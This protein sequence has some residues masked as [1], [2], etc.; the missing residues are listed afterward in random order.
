MVTRLFTVPMVDEFMKR[1]MP[2]WTPSP[3]RRLE[4]SKDPR[5]KRTA[6]ARRD[7]SDATFSFVAPTTSRRMV[8]VRRYVILQR[9]GSVPP[10]PTVDSGCL[11]VV[12]EPRSGLVQ[13]RMLMR[14]QS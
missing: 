11:F 3:R 14:F 8:S 12:C 4:T 7:G 13:W 1:S 5:A 10:P 2:V 9:G 6:R